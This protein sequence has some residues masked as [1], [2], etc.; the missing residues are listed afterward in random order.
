MVVLTQVRHPF[1]TGI[2]CAS[3]A[4]AALFLALYYP[5]YGTQNGWPCRSGMVGIGSPS[6]GGEGGVDAPPM[7]RH[8]SAGLGMMLG[9]NRGILHILPCCLDPATCVAESDA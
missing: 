5:R 6:G 1:E 9:G 8:D 3:E 2:L 4:D 7:A